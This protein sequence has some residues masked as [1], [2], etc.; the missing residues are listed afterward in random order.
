MRKEISG[1][2]V[3]FL[4]IFTLVSLVSYSPYDPSINNAADAGQIH[5]LF[6]IAGAHVAGL[7]IGLFGLGAFWIPFLLMLISVNLLSGKATG[8]S[9]LITLGGGFLLV[10]VTGALFAFGGHQ[11]T[12]FEKAFSSGG[13]VGTPLHHLVT[14]MANRV[15]AA[16]IFIVLFIVAL[17]L[18]T[19]F[20]LVAF[21]KQSLLFIQRILK[22]I[23]ASWV[24]FRLRPKKTKKLMVK[25]APPPKRS[26][27]KVIIEKKKKTAPGQ[28]C[29]GTQTAGL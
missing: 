29:G 9:I 6:G 5:N 25:K 4:V 17:I 7:F 13:I 23:Q 28:K 21:S 1:I 27:K 8:R 3:V 19:G 15:G 18:T 26:F 22:Q 12:L 16:L 11:I 24:K 14:K 10:V 2:L 20:S